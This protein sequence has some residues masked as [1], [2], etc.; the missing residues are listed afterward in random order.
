MN[1]FVL[2]ESPTKAAQMQCDK[3]VV[4]MILETGQ[5]LST[6]HRMYGNDDE[7][8]YKATH[9]HHP[10]T[11]WAAECRVNYQWLIEHFEALS[12][13]YEYRYG[14][15]HLTY[16]KLHDLLYNAPDG[17]PMGVFSL[18]TP[19]MPDE[20]KIPGDV[21]SSYRKYYKQH[22]RDFAKWTKRAV[23]VWFND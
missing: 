19:A 12:E 21:V 8:L 1:I 13:E 2:D 6:V 23:P 5:I 20:C 11:L 10:S 9:K 7:R 4:K 15:Q 18:P 14:K 17:M 16:T 22:K 3:H